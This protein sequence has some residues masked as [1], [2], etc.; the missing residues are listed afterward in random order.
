M[1]CHYAILFVIL[2]LNQTLCIMKTDLPVRK[3]PRAAFYDYCE[4][5]F[6]V[7]ICTK[8]KEHSFGEIKSGIMKY[9][10]TGHFCDI[11]LKEIPQHYPYAQVLVHQVMPNHLHAIIRIDPESLTGTHGSCDRR[12][13]NNIRIPQIRTLLGV[14]IGG[15]KRAV[16]MFARRNGEEFSWQT[17]YHDHKI[18]GISDGN[19]IWEYIEG[20]VQKWHEDCFNRWDRNPDPFNIMGSGISNGQ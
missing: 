13:E 10:L 1:F 9:T 20:N 4:G 15:I 2:P 17:R 6:F 7:T 19:M 5:D 16:T 3:S 18:R 8:E 14:V 11:Q 12:Q